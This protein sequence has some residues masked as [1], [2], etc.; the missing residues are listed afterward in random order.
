MK[1]AEHSIRHYEENGIIIA[2]VE[3]ENDD[4]IGLLL[5][6]VPFI[7]LRKGITDFKARLLKADLTARLYLGFAGAWPA[8]GVAD[9][10]DVPEEQQKAEVREFIYGLSFPPQEGGQNDGQNA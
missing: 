2:E 10:R 5:N 3:L 7:L 4:G 6:G 1:L 9:R 8:G